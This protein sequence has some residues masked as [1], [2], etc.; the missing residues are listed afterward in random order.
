MSS[1][2]RFTPH[3]TVAIV[4]ER[5]GMFLLVEETSGGKT[6]LNQPA[7]HL[8][9]DESLLDAAVRETLE[10]TGWA[11]DITHLIGIQLYRAPSNG[12]T[13]LR[14]TFSANPLE[15]RTEKLDDGIIAA[16]WLTESDI[17]SREAQLRSP[18]VLQ[19]VEAYLD[20]ICYPLS[21]LHPPVLDI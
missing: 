19:A 10:E 16:H 2:E 13:Y 8:E 1:I 11:V 18:L 6:V 15:R 21:I 4:V 20:G 14:A 3:V 9:K 17:R 12:V 5:D 7:G